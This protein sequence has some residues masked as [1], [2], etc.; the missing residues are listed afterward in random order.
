M[1]PTD[2]KYTRDHEWLRQ[3]GKEGTVGITD[4]AQHQLGDVV[5]V[6]LPEV[7]RRLVA[8]EA[9][10]VVESVKTVSDLYSPVNGKV[11]EVN[12]KLL[13]QPELVNGEPHGAG[14][15]IKVEIESLGDLLDA[16]AYQQLLEKEGH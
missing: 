9:F 2:L 4:F 8:G 16:E 7:G 11:V 12:Q 6:E 1:Y 5:F 3:S 14:W 15:M 10:G 13:E